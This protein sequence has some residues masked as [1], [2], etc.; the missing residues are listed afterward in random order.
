MPPRSDSAARVKALV[1]RAYLDAWDPQ[2]G[3]PWETRVNWS[4]LQLPD[5]ASFVA[6]APA[7]RK[8]SK[9]QR[10]R[11]K[12]LEM[13]SHLSQLAYGE[14]KATI[15]AGETATLSP[16]QGNEELWFLGTL[17]ADEGKHFE[18][19][20]RYLKS[21]LGQTPYPPDSSLRQVFQVLTAERDYE[22]NL[23]VGQVLLEG[24]AAS[25]LASLLLSIREPLLR[26][27]LR[28]ITLDEARH[29]KF[30]DLISRRRPGVPTPARRRRM[31]EILF[32]GA[33]AGA[34]SLMSSRAWK[35]QG[36]SPRMAREVTVGALKERGV[37]LFYTRILGRQLEQRGFPAD[38]LRRRLE[39]RL[40][41]RLKHGR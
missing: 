22:L 11:I 20:N 38:G 21:K 10:A 28:K 4:A 14:H 24:A 19:L 13:T 27:L 5:Q 30:A 31:E 9:Q 40:E 41:D 37:L 36:L 15:L 29:M 3:L 16:E 1:D 17:M 2:T 23:Y 26:E 12:R 35:D 34:S 6:Q 39:T 33:V 7:F 32:E 18:V 8:M 25:L